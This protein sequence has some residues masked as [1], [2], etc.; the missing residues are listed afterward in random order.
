MAIYDRN[1][2]YERYWVLL[3][4]IFR[5]CFRS[6]HFEGLDKI[7]TDGAI[8]YAPNHC[9]ALIDALAVLSID[10][11]PKVFV[12]RAD[13]FR[14]PK[15]AAALRWLKIM[16]I[17]RVRDGLDEVRHNDAT[18]QESVETLRHRVPFCI[19]AEGTHQP[20]RLILPL[21]KGIFRI[22]LQAAH[23]LKD[24]MP[25]YIVPVRLE[26]G[27]LYHLWDRLEVRMGEPMNITASIAAH[28][29]ATDPQLTNILLDTLSKR[30]WS[31]LGEPLRPK[32]VAPSLRLLGLVL[33]A[34]L[35]MV[36][37]LLT[38]PIWLAEIV[39]RHSVE[40]ECFHNSVM[41]V[42]IA[43]WTLL[44]LGCMLLPWMGLEEWRY[45]LRALRASNK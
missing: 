38:L 20:E 41:Y 40:D 30:M 19:M 12:A 3:G 33:T 14:K 7:P 32:M 13:I 37:A 22:A 1:I 17:R 26:F 28:E 2:R 9:N 25:V 43:I 5:R 45:Q 44:T 39:I 27:D 23:A 21:K 31:M 24:E 11:V 4:A 29:D 15:Q 35:A 34:P 10:N 42:W 8:I 18:I 6:L 16:P 36:C